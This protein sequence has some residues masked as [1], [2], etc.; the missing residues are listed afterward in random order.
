MRLAKA[1]KG[2]SEYAEAQRELRAALKRLRYAAERKILGKDWTERQA[3]DDIII[4]I[5]GDPTQ[6]TNAQRK[7][8]RPPPAEMS[9]AQQA[10]MDALCRPMN[11][12]L[13]AQLERRHMAIEALIAYCSVQE[14][15]STKIL[16]KAYKPATAPVPTTAE[17]RRAEEI[18]LRKAVTTEYDG[19]RLSMCFLCVAQAIAL[20][21]GDPNIAKLCHKFCS[22]A[23]MHRH[24]K[25]S[26]LRL[27]DADG[28]PEPCPV[29]V[30]KVT[31]KNMM[32]FRNHA[33]VIHG[34]R[35]WS[36]QAGQ[37]LPA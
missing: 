34:I 25:S 1:Q 23:S 32:Q 4:Q 12:T 19:Q 18:R 14:P 7:D 2:S 26:H 8:L 35:L 6:L 24:F 9:P 15:L 11:A 10:I 17:A 27:M 16:E 37:F 20:P 3:V 28:R 13:D 30:P 21:A 36:K 22:P 31:F 29:C 5:T 33:Q